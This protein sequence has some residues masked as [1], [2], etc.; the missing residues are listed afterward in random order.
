MKK[1]LLGI[2]SSIAAYRMPNLISQ[3]RKQGYEF[4]VIVTE[5]AEQ[6]VAVQALSVM[7]QH[8]CY[9]DQDEWGTTEQVLHIDL[10]KWCDAFLLAPLTA[11]TL[12]KMA[13]GICDNLLTSAVRA[14]GETPLIIAPAMNTRMWENAFTQ[15]HIQKLQ[16]VY[17]LTVIEPIT[18]KLADG[19]EGIGALAEDD[20]ILGV[21]SSL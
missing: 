19:D 18:K 12:A 20:T 15:E 13:N 6:F 3:G 11:N 9:R 5:K 10:A 1:I 16:E 14:L 4:R 17:N 2:T 21:L 7:S 8:Q